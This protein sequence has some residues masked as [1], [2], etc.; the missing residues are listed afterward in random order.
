MLSPPKTNRARPVNLGR[1]DTN[2][3]LI[4]LEL[5]IFKGLRDTQRAELALQ[6]PAV[7]LSKAAP[8]ALESPLGILLQ[9][10]IEVH[11]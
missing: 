6:L 4:G 8:H 9:L 1:L 10:A 11:N 5:L 2:C 3:T 7:F